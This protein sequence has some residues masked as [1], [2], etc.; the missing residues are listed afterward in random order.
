[1]ADQDER[2]RLEALYELGLLDSGPEADFDVLTDLAATVC[3]VR[4]AAIT[5]VDETRIWCKSSK[6]LDM[7]ATDTPWQ[8]AACARAVAADA[9]LII[10]DTRDDPLFGGEPLIPDRPDLRSYVGIPLSAPCGHRVG[11]LC[12]FHDEPLDPDPETLERLGTIARLAEEKIADRVE[13]NGSAAANAVL[14]AIATVQNEFISGDLTTRDSFDELLETVLRLTGSEY[15]FVGEV[16]EDETGR[17]IKTLAISNIAWDE[18]SRAFYDAHAGEGLEFRNLDTL[19]GHSLK[20]GETVLSNAPSEHPS[21]R[22]L[23]EGHPPLNA[24]AGVPLHSHGEL[25]AMLGL[26][27]RPGGFNT[28]VLEV[29]A[30]LLQTI[31]DLIHARRMAG[32]RD[33]ALKR[34]AASEHRY[35]L[36]VDGVF[37]GIWEIDLVGG[38]LFTSDRLLRILGHRPSGT[39]TRGTY[40]RDGLALM[41]SRV[42]PDDRSAVAAGLKRTWIVREPCELTYRYRHADGH[43]VHL[44]VRGMAE[45]DHT[46]RAVRMAG[47]AEDITERLQQAEVEQRTQARLA[48]VTQLGGFGAWETDLVAETAEWDDIARQIIEVDDDFRPDMTSMFDF[49]P[50]GY[51]EYTRAAFRDA[52]EN[53]RDWD[54]EIPLTTARGRSIWVRVIGRPITDDGRVVKLIGS[55][56]DITERK[57]REEEMETLSSRLSMALA[58]SGVGVWEFDLDRNQ[59]WWDEGCVRMFGNMPGDDEMTFKVWKDRVHPDDLSEVMGQIDHTIRSGEPI[60]F[61]YRILMQDGSVR[62]LRVNA[63]YKQTAGGRQLVSGTNFEITNDVVTAQELDRR[64]VEAEAAN[65]AKSRFLANMSHEIRTPL[66]GVLGMAQLLKMTHLDAKQSQFV[67]TL[68]SSG[69]AL[70]DLIED[71]LDISKI[72]SGMVE[73]ARSPFRLADMVRGATDVVEP[74]ARE[75]GLDVSAEIDP[76]IPAILLGDEKRVRQVLINIIGNAVKFTD[77]GAVKV[78]V[79]A[80]GGDR[81]RFDVI[82]N[83]PGIP[84]DR[85]EQVFDRFAQ[86]DESATRK[87]GGTGLG[88]AICREIVELA[89]GTIGV[90]SAPGDGANFHFELPLPAA[91]AGADSELSAVHAG[92]DGE[93]VPGRV[94]VVDDVET[95]RVVAAALVRNAGHAVD[96]AANGIEALAALETADYDVVLMDIQMPVMSGDEAIEH[97]R[98]SGEPY[99]DLPIFAVTADATSGAR[100]RYMGS[101]ATGYLSK[102]LDMASVD[103][104]L[105]SVF[106]VRKRA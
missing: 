73:L 37:A 106:P 93:M 65:A 24:Y 21:A 7:P 71:V 35:N 27:N 68:Q 9:P 94:L 85:L 3:G 57:Q 39:S 1:M 84:V 86:V 26:A 70:L 36:A 51:H 100:E 99:A 76:E 45:W 28:R 60:R 77:V 20:T 101:G 11:V 90:D 52:V 66:N 81:V 72:E 17:Y 88:L 98:S 32:A 38:D 79:S 102:P 50:S 43:Y 15:G 63:S 58:A 49:M 19:Y 23:P 61:E 74:T 41:L 34:L 55:L 4:H 103:A 5:L 6:G 46:G 105:R 53:Q 13:R 25:V 29:C 89:G 12:V 44:F 8:R 75:K 95:N 22:G 96:V 16:R 33:D 18:G 64:R 59:F 48:A 82:D 80:A 92:A 56:Q 67:E 97:I 83:G 91:L 78:R 87:H 31:G 10:A 47:S 14:A 2:K 104:A 69:R 54:I 42:H 30:P 40:A 62:H